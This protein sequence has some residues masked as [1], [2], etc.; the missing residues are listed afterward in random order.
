LHYYVGSTEVALG[1]TDDEFEFLFQ[2]PWFSY[3]DQHTYPEILSTAQTTLCARHT[4]D[5]TPTNPTS[6]IIKCVETDFIYS[7]EHTITTSFVRIRGRSWGKWIDEVVEIR[8]PIP[9][10]TKMIWEYVD[11][12]DYFCADQAGTIVVSEMNTGRDTPYL[13]TWDTWRTRYPIL[14]RVAN[15]TSSVQDIENGLDTVEA[16]EVCIH[17]VSNV[18][19]PVIDRQFEYGIYFSAHTGVTV[20]NGHTGRRGDPYLYIMDGTTLKTLILPQLDDVVKSFNPYPSR[21]KISVIG[22]NEDSE[23]VQFIDG[24]ILDVQFE[25]MGVAF[26]VTHIYPDGTVMSVEKWGE[27]FTDTPY[28]T[29]TS[30]YSGKEIIPITLT[31]QGTHCVTAEWDDVDSGRTFQHK[32]ALPVRAMTSYRTQVLTEYLTA[33]TAIDLNHQGILRVLDGA[34]MKRF[35]PYY[36]ICLLDQDNDILYIPT[37]QDIYGS[38]SG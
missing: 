19:D 13:G 22:S 38:F 10:Q 20:Y 3:L 26:R 18:T 35:Y 33:P 4:V 6:L 11:Y 32:L 9:Y 17:F 21:V 29:G 14:Y 7:N 37:W 5:F 8:E 12:I 25:A 16:G 36:N 2:S 1:V 28:S 31:G 15:T 23:R 34:T 30:L 24:C 27:G